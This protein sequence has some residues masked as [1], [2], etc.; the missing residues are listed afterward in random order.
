MDAHSY[1]TIVETA[2]LS[3]EIRYTIEHILAKNKQIILC[4]YLFEPV[5]DVPVV[6]A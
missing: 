5:D 2:D 1:Y 3:E 4:R 6:H